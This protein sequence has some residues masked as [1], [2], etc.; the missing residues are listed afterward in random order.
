MSYNI[1]RKI[2]AITKGLRVTVI[3]LEVKIWQVLKKSGLILHV[4]AFRFF[5]QSISIYKIAKAI[6]YE[7]ALPR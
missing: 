5:F 1:Y 6:L 3:S 4:R 2:I 7:A